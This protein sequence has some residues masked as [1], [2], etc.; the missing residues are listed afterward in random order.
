MLE[1]LGLAGLFAAAFL[2]LSLCAP[3]PPVRP[4]PG[5]AAGAILNVINQGDAVLA[6][7]PVD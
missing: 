7:L 4:P 1:S 3:T 5:S 6:G 2:V